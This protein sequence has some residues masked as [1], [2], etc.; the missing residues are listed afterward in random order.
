MYHQLGFALL[1]KA[2]SVEAAVDKNQG[3]T[4]FAVDPR[5]MRN[6]GHGMTFT[7]RESAGRKNT[8]M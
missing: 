6:R 8:I 7:D 5:S 1:E 2:Q 4:C 3:V